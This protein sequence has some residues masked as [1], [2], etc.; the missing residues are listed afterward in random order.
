M[1]HIVGYRARAPEKLSTRRLPP[2]AGG[3]TL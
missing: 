3:L 2:A 1:V